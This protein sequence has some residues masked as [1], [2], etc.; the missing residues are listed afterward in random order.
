VVPVWVPTSAACA[1]HAE[2]LREHGGLQ[3]PTGEAA[4][5]STLARPRQL[6]THAVPT[7]TI[8]Q[9]A[10]AY[11][12]GLATNHCFPDGN[13]RITL[14]IIDVFLQLNGLELIVREEDA[15]PTI[16]SLAAGELSESEL[17]DWILLSTAPCFARL[18]QF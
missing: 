12:F 13:K 16:R 8:A 2:L 14:A 3:G 18:H 15:V 10:A 5:E 4:L 6:T 17:A 7:P 9:L 1:I 11:G